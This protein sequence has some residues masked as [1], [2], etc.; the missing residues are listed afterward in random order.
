MTTPTDISLLIYLPTYNRFDKVMAQIANI[1]PHIVGTRMH[2]YVSD[3]CSTDQRY[4]TL[5]ELVNPATTTVVRQP[6]NIGPDLNIVSGF[7]VG[8]RYDYTWI[9][10]DDDMLLPSGVAVALQTIMAA[11]SADIYYF[12]DPGCVSELIV[13][14]R[15]QKA[16]LA[17]LNEGLGLISRVIY[18]TAYTLPYVRS[19]FEAVLCSFAHLVTLYAA[20]IDHGTVQL[21]SYPAERV[22]VDE[23][24][25]PAANPNFHVLYYE[26]HLADFIED[27]RTRQ[28]FLC[29]WA[30]GPAARGAVI[31]RKTHQDAYR[32]LFGYLL[33]TSLRAWLLM[34]RTALLVI[35]YRAVG[36]HKLKQALQRGHEEKS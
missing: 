11:P 25:Q 3:N 24:L 27:P 28:Q 13:E 22:F 36:G 5:P 18:R 17:I 34:L 2:L 16:L 6:T 35:L 26:P 33:V 20:V 15:D 29:G 9:L 12:R 31:Y 19:G 14:T 8:G 10:S 1:E 30:S 21:A 7:L 4:L 23:P 32:Q